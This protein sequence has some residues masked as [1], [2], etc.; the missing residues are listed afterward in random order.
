MYQLLSKKSSAGNTPILPAQKEQRELTLSEH[1]FFDVPRA[2][3]KCT[4]KNSR[5]AHPG[6]RLL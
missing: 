6:A 3:L 4:I 1:A 5:A 2:A